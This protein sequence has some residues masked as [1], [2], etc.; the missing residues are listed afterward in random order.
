MKEAFVHGDA[1]FFELFE[2]WCEKYGKT[3]SEEEKRYSFKVFKDNYPVKA[4]DKSYLCL[5]F[6]N[7]YG[8]IDHPNGSSH[9]LDFMAPVTIVN[10]LNPIF[11]RAPC[12]C[13]MT[14]TL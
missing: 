10:P 12:I 11:H 8:A 9:P 7:E 5:A 3:Y 6:L 1:N 4:P 2:S 13:I 14:E